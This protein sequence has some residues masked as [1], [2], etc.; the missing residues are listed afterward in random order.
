L[1]VEIPF[2]QRVVHGWASV[3]SAPRPG[4]DGGTAT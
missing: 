4:G 1:N 2:P 3:A